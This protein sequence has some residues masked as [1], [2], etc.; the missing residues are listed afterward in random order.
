MKVCS[1]KFGIFWR[2]LIAGFVHRL[3]SARLEITVNKMAAV[4]RRV[5][6]FHTEMRKSLDLPADTA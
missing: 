5:D 4:W 2:C 6:F 3:Q 1:T